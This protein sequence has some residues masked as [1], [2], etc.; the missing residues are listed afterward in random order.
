MS[1]DQ[2][3]AQARGCAAHTGGSVRKPPTVGPAGVKIWYG[4]DGTGVPGSAWAVP[5]ITMAQAAST[6]AQMICLVIIASEPVLQ[7]HQATGSI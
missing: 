3:P 2:F 6:A 1:G 5:A 7:L 4:G